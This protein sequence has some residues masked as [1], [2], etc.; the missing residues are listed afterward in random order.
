MLDYDDVWNNI[1]NIK[2]RESEKKEYLCGF[3]GYDDTPRHG[4][5]GTVVIG[6]T[7]QK[8]KNY[9]IRLLLKTYRRNCDFLFLNAWNEW[10]EGMYLEPDKKWEFQYLEALRDAKEFVQQEG[11]VV[12]AAGTDDVPL[13]D[14]GKMEIERLSYRCNRYENFYRTFERMLNLKLEGRFISK[15]IYN[16]KYKDVAIYGLGIIGKSLVKVLM[17]EK[18]NVVYGIDQNEYKGRIFE[19]PVYTLQEELK[20]I[21]IIIV[22]V[23]DNDSHIKRELENRVKAEIVSVDYLLDVSEKESF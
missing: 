10:G 7:P 13:S 23:E 2:I 20:D 4:K 18:I 14:C 12:L 5:N 17:D 3:P 8:F 16:K 6:A 1:L 19:F 9:M 21:D 11:D 22:T 15:Y